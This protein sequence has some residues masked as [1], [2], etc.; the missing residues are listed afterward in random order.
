MIQYHILPMISGVVTDKNTRRYC[1]SKQTI[2][3]S[4]V[5]ITVYQFNTHMKTV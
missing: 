2:Y 5:L 3:K 1:D 4:P